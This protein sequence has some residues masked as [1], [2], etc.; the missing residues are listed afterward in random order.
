[1]DNAIVWFRDDLRLQDNPAFTAAVDNGYRVIPLVISEQTVPASA[2]TWWRHYALADFQQSIKSSGGNLCLRLG[3]AEGVLQTLIDELQVK[4]VFWNRRYTPTGIAID[5]GMKQHF[6]ALGL[7][8]KTFNAALIKE[9]WQILN[10]TQKPYRVFTPYWKACL[11]EGLAG[12]NPLPEK[13]I[14]WLRTESLALQ[15]LELLDHIRWDKQF[16]E[17]WK[18]TRAEGLEQLNH[19]LQGPVHSYDCDRDRPDIVGTTRLSPYLHSGLIGVREVVS[20]IELETALRSTRSS[21]DSASFVTGC[22]KLLSE[23]G[24]REFS[25]YLLYHHPECVREP[26]QESFKRF[27]WKK[28][29]KLLRAWQSGQTGYPIVDAGMRE[30]WQTG[31]MHNRVRMIVASFLVKHLMQPWQEGADWFMQTLLDADLASNTQGWQWTSGCGVDA[32]PFF[33]VFNPVSQGKK[34]DPD[35]AYVRRWVPELK[36][37]PLKQVHEPWLMD[38]GLQQASNCVVGDQYPKPIVD[39][40]QGRERALEAWQSIRE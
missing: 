6:K 30:L 15:E 40:K 14:H 11:H 7:E 28:D 22:D 32:S 4:A 34:F 17:H 3:R 27:P 23:L 21:V 10:K 9:P 8:V 29:Q 31:W 13:K 24:W 16:P 5:T 37:V 35:G 38:A 1:M 36:R 19:F 18:P 26:L 39:L 33:R 12:A 2:H 20:A 25:Y